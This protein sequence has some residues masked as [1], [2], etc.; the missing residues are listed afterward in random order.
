MPGLID[1]QTIEVN[2]LPVIWSPVQSPLT[3]EEKIRELDQQATASLLWAAT[4]PE[5][6][7]RLLLSETDIEPISDPPAGYDPDVQGEWDSSQLTFAFSRVIR[8]L[9]EDRRPDRLTVEYKVDGAGTW[10]VEIGL[11]EVSVARI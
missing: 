11:E 5:Q 9:R 6:V 3:E 8:L 1:P 10:I 7:L 4:I 2:G